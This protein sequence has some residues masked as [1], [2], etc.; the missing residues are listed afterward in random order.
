[1]R[2]EK[3]M[4]MKMRGYFR[5]VLAI[6]LVIALLMQGG[7]VSA[8]D[9]SGSSAQET[10]VSV[11]DQNSDADTASVTQAET[12]TVTSV[13][14]QTETQSA[15]SASVQT[16]TQLSASMS[17]ETETQSAAAASMQTETESASS[18]A[19][20]SSETIAAV[21]SDTSASATSAAAAETAQNFETQQQSETS[22]TTAM[23]QQNFEGYTDS[24]IKV[25]AS[26]P[27]GAFPEG[28]TMTVSDVSRDTAIS[29]AK[30]GSDTPEDVVD[31]V[32]VDIVFTDKDGQEIE[33]ADGKQISVEMS[34][35]ETLEGESFSVVHDDGENGPTEIA[36]ATDSSAAFKTDSF[37]IYVIDGESPAVATYRFYDS[38]GNLL[39]Y[40]IDNV[41]F[42]EQKIK[43][44]ETLYSPENPEKTG[45]IFQ[46]WTTTEGS[47]T[48]DLEPFSSI[49][50]DVTETQTIDY[51]PVFEEAHY[52]FFMDSTGTDGTVARVYLTK[53]GVSGD[54]ITTTDVTLSSAG[55]TSFTGWYTDTSLSTEAGDSITLGDE[56]I[57]L[58]PKFEEG[59]YLIFKT[60]DDATII[61]PEFVA[62]D[63]VTTAPSDPER[64]GYTFVGWSTTENSTTADFTFGSE[65]TA[66]TT[67]Y[68]VW[69]P[70][71]TTYTVIFW[72]QSVTDDK[73]A[74]D[75][76]KTYE[77]AGSETRTGTTESYASATTSD[78]SKS[79]IND[80]VGFHF[81]STN[82]VS[83]QIEGDGSTILNI[84]YDRD[85]FTYTF[86]TSS[87]YGYTKLTS[88]S[89]LYGA[90]MEQSGV[91]WPVEDDSVWYCGSN[92]Y[93]YS[94][95]DAFLP[96]KNF[97]YYGNTAEI[98][99]YQTSGS[100]TLNYYREAVT[101]GGFTSD[102]T[103]QTFSL[104]TQITGWNF[105]NVYSGF[106]VS[107]FRVMDSSGNYGS[108]VSV[109]SDGTSSMDLSDMMTYSG[110]YTF[111][112][113]D[114]FYSRNQHSIVYYSGNEIIHEESGIYYQASL[115]DYGETGSNYYEPEEAPSTVP[116]GSVFAGWYKDPECT[117]PYDFE[118]ST[119]PDDDVIVYAKWE[120]PTVNA[121]V[122]DEMYGGNL[123][124]TITVDYGGTVDENLM[125]NVTNAS[126]DYIVHTSS[127]VTITIPD[128][129]VWIGW[130]V[131]VT[132]SDGNVTSYETYSFDTQLTE[133]IKLYPHYFEL[134]TYHITYDA[135]GG[136]GTVTD[137]RNY[138]GGD[139]CY[140]DVL[141]GGG[142]TPPD[143]QVFLYWNTEA[144]GSGTTYYP[145]DKVLMSGDVTLYAIYGDEPDATDLTYYSN[146]PSASG[147]TDVTTQQTV[148]DETVLINNQDL[149]LYT[150]SDAGMTTPSG[151]EFVGWN[152]EADGSGDSYAAG[153]TVGVD[154]E[155]PQPNV[156]YAIWA[157]EPTKDVFKS[158]DTSISIDG[159]PVS[160]G[161]ELLYTI[162]YVNTTGSAVT[163]T[164]TDAIPDNSTYVDESADNGGSC[165]NDTVTWSGLSVAA[166]GSITV[167]FKVTVD[168]NDGTALKNSATVTAG[169][170][171]YTTNE[172]TNPTP[173]EPTKD[174]FDSDDETTSIDGDTVSAGDT[175]TYKITYTN[176]TGSDVTVDITD[177]IPDNSTYVDG[178]ADNGGTYTDGT[179]VWSD[180][181]VASGDS[182]TVSFQVTVDSADG[183]A[184][185]NTA[186][187]NDGI[188]TYTTNETTNPTGTNPSKDVFYS[189]DE[190]TSINGKTVRAGEELLYK[191]TYTNTT[192]DTETV[193]ITDAIPANSTFVSADNEG[194]YADSTDTITWSDITLESG[195][196]ITVSFTVTVDENDGTV[197]TNDA[198]VTVGDNTYTTNVTKNPTPTEPT[199]DV[200]D[201]GDETT[202][203]DGDLV[204]AGDTLIYKITYSNTTADTET[205][206]ITDAIPANSTFVSADNE[207]TYADS[208]GTIT[209]SNITLTSGSSITVSFTVTVDENDGTALTNQA[210]VSDGT[211]TYTTNETTNPTPTDPT[212]DVFDSDSETA[213]SIDGDLVEAGDTLIYKITYENTTGAD[214]AVK[215]TD[216]IPDNST[217]VTGSA[218]D[219]G[220][221][222]NGTV[223]WN[224]S[225]T[226]GE[227]VTV[228]F[229]VTVD[230][231][232]GTVLNNTADVKVGENTYTTN[233]TTNP[234]PTEPTKDVSYSDDE[235][236]ASIDGDLVKEGEE[237]LYTITYANTTGASASVTITDTI[238]DNS[239]YVTGS[240][241]NDG[242]YSD[243]DRTVTWDL[244][245]AKD[246]SITVSFKVTVVANDGTELKN[247]AVVTVGEN[248]YTT[249][250]TTNP[251]PTDPTKDVFNSSD[252]STSIDGDLVEAGD[253]LL[254]TITYTNT[255][256]SAETVTIPDSIPE[257]STYV[258]DSADNGG[259][260]SDDGTLVW[261]DIS[262]ADGDSIT[263]SFKVTVDKNDGTELINQ[264][265]VSDGTN[266]FTTNKTT[267]PTPTE[268]TKD[269][270]DSGD[271]TTS[272]DGNT[273]SAGDELLYMITYTNTTGADASVTITDTIPA[274]S[275]YVTG[276]ADNSGTYSE[277]D[278]TVTW[279]ATV[280]AGDSITVSFRVTVDAN[281]G[282]TL[283][284][285]ADVTVGDNTYTTN[286]TKN[287]TPTEPVKD[288]FYSSDT[289]HSID[290][291][292]V[293][294]GDE[295]L[296]T[297]TYTNTTGSDVTVDITDA[298]PD[299]S[300]YV[301]GSA[302]N[303]GTYAD[304]TL[305]W[306]DIAVAS[307]GSITVSFR[308]T[309]DSDDG[310]ALKNSADV[311]DGLNDYTTNETTN[312]TGKNPTKDVFDSSDTSTSI[313]GKT[314]EAGDELLYKITYTNTTGADATVTITDSIPEGSTYVTGSADNSGSYA[315]DKVTW[316]GIE[317]ADGESITVSFRVTVDANDGTEL[318]NYADAVVG[319]NTYTTNV[320]KNPTPTEPEKDVFDSG[321]D[322]TSIDGETVEAGDELLYKITYTNTTGAAETVTITDKIP[323][324]STYVEGSV[325]NGG[326]YSNGRLTWSNVAL[327]DGESITVSFRVTVDENDGTEL[328]NK[329][330]VSDGTN[331]YTTNET[332]NPTPTEPEKDVFKSSDTLTSID[333]KTVT[334][335][336][337]LLYTI[338]YTNTTDSAVT[339]TIT[340][341]IPDNS[342]YVTNSADNDGVYADGTLTWSDI[343]VAAGGSVTVSFKVTVV[344]DDGTALKNQAVVNDGSNDYTTNI[345]TNPTGDNPTKDVFD[346][347]DTSTSIDGDTV[348]AGDE[349]LYKVTYTNTTGS[350]AEVDITDTIPAG[351]TYVDGSADNDGTYEN[352]VLTWSDISL[353]SG[354]SITV[355]F[356]VTVDENDGT[357]LKNYADA[358]V[359]EN[360]YTTNVTTNPTPSEPE[361]DVFQSSDTSTSIDGD[362]VRAGDELTY[363][364]TYTNTTSSDATVTI[365]DTIPENSTYVDGSADNGGT[366][367]DG[368]LTWSDI[369]VAS[370]ES[371][372]VSF[373]VTVDEDN[374]TALTN[375]AAVSDGTNTYTTNETTNPTTQNPSKDVFA[376]TD[377][378]NS[379]DGVTVSAG[380]ELLYKI[381]Y[382]NTT[383]SA[384]TVTITDSIPDN[385]TY[386]ADSADNGGTYEDGTLTWSGIEL[387]SGENIT[388]SFKVTVNEDNGTTLTNQAT[389]SD[390]ENDY[391]TNE[392]E[393]PTIQNPSKD[394]FMSSDETTS[395]DGD[396]VRAG[397]ELTYKITYVNTTGSE[398]DVTITDSI[399]A[400]STYVTNSADNGG[401]YENGTLTWSGI[402]LAAGE[403]ITVSFSVTV[404][405]DDGTE[406]T[407]DADVKVGDNTYTT[408]VTTNPTPTEPEKDVF[409]SSD[410]STSI[411]GTTVYEGDELLYTITYTNTTGSNETVTITDTIPDNS[412]YV[413]GSADNSGAYSDGTLTWSGIA[414]ADGESITVSFKVTVDANDGTA[415]TN[416]A[417]VNDGTNTFTTNETT[418]PTPT[419]PEK[420][421]FLSSDE[422]TSIDGETVNAGD[423][424][425]YKITYT[426]TTGSDETVTITDAIPD[427]ST[428]VT[429]SADNSGVYADGTIVWSDLAVASG[430]SITVS[431][432]VTVDANDATTLTNEAV[433][434]D[435]MNTYTTNETTNPTLSE[436]EALVTIDAEKVLA[437]GTLS[438]GQFSFELRDQD[439]ATVQIAQNT[440]DGSIAFD[441]ISF[442]KEGTWTYTIREVLP[443]DDDS[444]VDGIQK[445]GITYDETVY[446]ATVRVTRGADTGLLEASVTYRAE[447]TS[448]STDLVFTN[449]V[450][451][452]EETEPPTQTPEEPTTEQTTGGRDVNTGDNSHIGLYLILMIVCAALLT[453]FAVMR[454]RE[455]KEQE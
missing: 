169:D 108:W 285:D 59:H 7:I 265:T 217:Y 131:A 273:V 4:S 222:S 325:D 309:V 395:I 305:T 270:F 187:V 15:A 288:V 20:T 320:T 415:L 237:L 133:D 371:I 167:S 174:V 349:L 423:E 316:S 438:D 6:A 269:V 354:E 176:T 156:L 402:T 73:D 55:T 178:S 202:S 296:Y 324:N 422:S 311:S 344:A 35:P 213:E 448:D 435:G 276:S 268:P 182:I 271:E 429:D 102:L 120:L 287:P 118:N 400:N 180:I 378:L 154:V 57:Y 310:T 396:L 219:D 199:K 360:T 86:Y 56:N 326:I 399:P 392:T 96:V 356:M 266:T 194:T 12:Q 216:T 138:A 393:N 425:T 31:A 234:T 26:A 52:V 145:D 159:D 357:V 164:I 388:V 11:S 254:Y 239:K 250:E 335:G 27:E 238:P 412:T 453:I 32:G 82:T 148:D 247:D 249:N 204:E 445:D 413:T 24:G 331:T 23:P 307:G 83:V 228:S 279:S 313:D 424:L 369:A 246:A 25:T 149:T 337:E 201:S 60:G 179:L 49:T 13:S 226:K 277:D 47:D 312:P 321:D 436:T 43:D 85:L 428:Y 50:P 244:T 444:S 398:A 391:T 318:T 364:I 34:L 196:S 327:A 146:Y 280:S 367:T 397:D 359:G 332:T 163:V 33:P 299:N 441:T 137:S 340:D 418:N 394:V 419:E 41:T 414:L 103:P 109:S 116:E 89:G 215:I 257:N 10:T 100:Y 241:D 430:E 452:A 220:T 253:E 206:T 330:V 90:T 193:T 63:D 409:E 242:T 122:Y 416:E 78:M 188:N 255:T 88:I 342:T 368:T 16:E 14:Q 300:T 117:V 341:T 224:L 92:Q 212:K 1:M 107:A 267:N 350:D 264:A 431:F 283:T 175:L 30:E 141:S 58:Y 152:T 134:N 195:S 358:V 375:E 455:K 432:T 70:A 292:T 170:N 380:D 68:A 218:S 346:S 165:E 295:L 262:L 449:E 67:L 46:G 48:V 79:S 185:K 235:T 315:D 93:Y 190:S 297:I 211:N 28:T 373:N 303:G 377:P 147:L 61:D 18:A 328:T 135:N 351:S 81:N 272:I 451:P 113:F 336:D 99:F 210:T 323:E 94:Y 407:N 214:A 362:T 127:S 40:T 278:G 390:G 125:P 62:A 370:G 130:D 162:T 381:T 384:S 44:G 353:A 223:T 408:N 110:V 172:T 314:V 157:A 401:T 104:D 21:P 87:W 230:A 263:V 372:T 251:T 173:T 229:S 209:W 446:V 291:D 433:V 197:L 51:Y 308:V 121:E 383:G 166:G 281:D 129:A 221:Y 294:A 191:I 114:V 298:I 403:S 376:S 144:D 231:N 334:A 97:Y 258:T 207:G 64:A 53:E 363:T 245:V 74:A 65:L 386:V 389:V 183:T 274:G 161:D 76:D 348:Q 142:L 198:D 177:A 248:T 106:T 345:T 8:G 282:S 151:Y 290:G 38:D 101:G 289:A 306:S 136:D 29:I 158:S 171:T 105:E 260:Y 454:R 259:S 66:D 301:D 160:A 343:A 240:A 168:A 22:E 45:Y 123:V 443:D 112:G 181:A 84:Y 450:V 410:T 91:E 200:F 355:S 352:G 339:V 333:G 37:S 203:I 243:T 365:T 111:G 284:N 236:A 205:V 9:A 143:G 439:G 442:E 261:S 225:V 39:T 252:T 232:D 420:D 434:N 5:S 426:N 256:G 319:E 77:Y 382:R 374:G 192:A 72:K 405:A 440:S 189:D 150:L 19:E 184:L 427:N 132:D 329:A 98:E 421:V 153:D 71:T 286:V 379:I 128:D 69:E 54:S 233:E 385:S 42:S 3:S 447:G 417:V 139:D 317:L 155:T 2:K 140:A 406:L 115:A 208:T 293:R 17:A 347:S 302:D 411:D 361:K 119:M 437:G 338:T 404:N 186:T 304:G 126:G 95:L 275:T 75:A 80:G 322:T 36:D 366:Y 387:S 124:D 227:T